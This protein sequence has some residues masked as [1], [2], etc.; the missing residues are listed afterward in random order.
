MIENLEVK[1]RSIQL[2][3]I[4]NCMLL[5]Y[6]EGWNQTKND[7]K[8]L[9]EN[10]LNTSLLAE[11][12][13]KIIGSAIAMNYSNA[14][15]WIGMV[16]VDKA[17]RG[18]GISKMLLQDLLNQLQ[19]CQSVKLDATPAGRPVYK[20]Y[21]FK[22]EYIIH[23]MT[24]LSMEK[25]QPLISSIKAEPILSS[26]VTEVV[27]LDCLS[28]GA[29][30][31]FLLNSLIAENPGKCWCVKKN[32]RI[33]ALALGRQGNRYHHIG[34]VSASTLEEAKVL[35]S[36]C[37]LLLVGQPVVLDILSDKKEL[38]EWLVSIGFTSQRYFVRMYLDKNP[39][40]GKLENQFLICGPEFG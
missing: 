36:H 18:R 20:K 8:R 4:E 23:R 16:L 25:F 30:R 27:G 22:D 40:P 3:D 29:E 12:E 7:W 17:F 34:P 32:G 24:N 19:S 10:P 2:E 37:L 5:S 6:S 13:N 9:V 31:S 1:L 35:I 14:V 39:N 11:I 15:V 33:T 38:F 28:F 26:D 21:Q